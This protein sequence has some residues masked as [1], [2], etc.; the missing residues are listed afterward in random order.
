[1]IRSRENSIR[2]QAYAHCFSAAKR[3]AR[4]RLRATE[5]RL[6]RH[7]RKRQAGRLAVDLLSGKRTIEAPRNNSMVRPRACR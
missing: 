1:M 6:L 5:Q 2:I 4:S 7:D 3:R